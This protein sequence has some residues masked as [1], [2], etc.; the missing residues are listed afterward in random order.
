MAGLRARWSTDLGFAIVDPEVAEI[1]RA[2]AE[3]LT[4]AAGLAADEEPGGPDR[5][6]PHLAVV[7]V[8]RPVVLGRP[9]RSTPSDR[10]T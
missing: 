9:T 10:T 7:G 3:R 2:A 5:P 4:A 6:G 8:A 1:A